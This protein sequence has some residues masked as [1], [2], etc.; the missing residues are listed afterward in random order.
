MQILVLGG[1][2]R[3]G[4]LVID[5]A[6]KRGHSVSV[7]VSHEYRLKHAPRLLD[8]HEGTPLN[9][10]TLSAAMKGCDA[11][12]S[13]L[14]ISR[15]SDF[16]W[17]ALRTS[18]DFLSVSMKNILEASAE[19][20]VK[21]IIMTSAWGV[22]ETWKDIPFWFRWLVNNSNIHYAYYEHERQEELLKNSDAEWTA[23]R[24]AGL[25]DSMKE[26]EI[27]V[28]LNNSPKPSLTISR[29]NTAKFMLD[30]LEKGLYIRQ[31]PVISEKR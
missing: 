27:K 23:V 22:G 16:P 19:Q 15:M 2:G 26:R 28:S 3:T 10:Y 13:T 14:N 7:V 8:V 12:I 21:R 31:C 18:E 5:E 25:T 11:I 17:A 1:T 29:L 20:K 4:R 9:K 24:P 6:L 30:V